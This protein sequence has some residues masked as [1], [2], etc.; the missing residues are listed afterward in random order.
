MQHS[1]GGPFGG[2]ERGMERGAP[3]QHQA[4]NQRGLEKQMGANERATRSGER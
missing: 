2:G 1:G 4:A 3:P